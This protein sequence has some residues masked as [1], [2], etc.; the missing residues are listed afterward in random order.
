MID[1]RMNRFPD[2]DCD[3]IAG[4]CQRRMGIG[5]DGLILLRSHNTVDFTM[6]YFNSDGSESTMCG[7]GGR[8]LVQ[9][10]HDLKIISQ[11]TTFEAIDGMHHA[12]VHEDGTVSLH[13]I[14]TS[15][16]KSSQ[17]GFFLD[18]GSPHHVEFIEKAED[19][20]VVQIGRAHRNTIYGPQGANINFVEV[21]DNV[22]IVRTYERGVEDETYSCGTGVT[23][24]AIVA[25]QEGK[26]SS[27]PV[28][29][30]TLGGELSVSF[31][32]FSDG[33]KNVILRGPAIFVFEGQL[34]I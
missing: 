14:D 15:R 32:S 4:L 31:K 33:F 1:D 23:A 28:K 21:A 12:E 7:N 29:V 19:Y 9:F 30:H 3:L 27:N 13:M 17:N 26:I 18:T 25:F 16:S 20:P 5:S 24:A 10:A 6:V 2:Q 8:C 34:S 22:L 11:K